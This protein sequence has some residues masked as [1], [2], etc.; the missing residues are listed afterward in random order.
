MS[1]DALRTAEPPAVFG[2]DPVGHAD[3]V[4]ALGASR[5]PSLTGLRFVAAFL[6][7]GLHLMLQ[8]LFTSHA[9]TRGGAAVFGAGTAGVSF[10][11]ILSGFVLTWSARPGDT[12]ARFWRRRAAKVYPNHLV[13]AALAVGAPL[14]FGGAISLGVLAANLP[15]VQAWIP[16]DTYFYGLNT[17]SWSLSCEVFF[18]LC[19]PLLLAG[20]D[21]LPGRWLWPATVAGLGV[22]WLMPAL[23]LGLPAGLRT[24]FVLIAPPVRMVEFVIGI[25]L[26]RIV[27]A[28][29]WIGLG[30]LPA[31][32]LA[33][34][35]YVCAGLVPSQLAHVAVT[36]VPFALLIP[37]VACA[38]VRDTRSVLCSRPMVWLGEISFA[39]YLLHQIVIRLAYKLIGKHALPT[40][41]GLVVAVGMLVVSVVGAW[42]LYRLVEQPLMR[43]LGGGRRRPGGVH[44]RRA[45]GSSPSRVRHR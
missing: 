39:F 6:V 10:F 33:V 45:A 2:T 13:T 19:F 36:V 12:A 32:G 34:G 1:V 31:A 14:A 30:V 7:F 15:L 11:F 26:A 43:R 16:S 42:V 24:W 35:G 4:P 38:D 17:P 28:G 9:V 37:A 3:R 23:A 21:R 20:V 40:P 41:A 5:L 27:Q 18:Y 22:V 44:R 25:L 29:R 8:G